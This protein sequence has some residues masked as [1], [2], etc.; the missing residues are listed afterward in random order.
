M[1]AGHPFFAP[2]KRSLAAAHVAVF[3]WVPQCLAPRGWCGEDGRHQ[4][5]DARSER[6][7]AEHQRRD[8]GESYEAFVWRL[9]EASAAPTPPAGRF[10]SV[11]P[12]AKEDGIE[13]RLGA[14]AW[15][16]REDHQDGG[17]ADA[18]AAQGQA[19]G[20][21]LDTGAIVGLTVQDASAHD[22]RRSRRR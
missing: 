15:S 4:C 17:W 7:N 6:G 3:T 22:P 9:A 1:N 19:H 2:P 14:S 8:T 20:I 21:D 12:V 13:Q 16:G 5:H 10:G 18:L 11:R